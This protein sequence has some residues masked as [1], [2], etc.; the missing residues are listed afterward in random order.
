MC[1]G[2]HVDI[3]QFLQRRM[4]MATNGDREPSAHLPR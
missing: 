4:K 2:V 3:P 1:S